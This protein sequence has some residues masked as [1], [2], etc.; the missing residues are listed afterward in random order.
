MDTIARGALADL[1]NIQSV[2]PAARV[3]RNIS[4]ELHDD[5]TRTFA[6]ESTSLKST[7]APS[8]EPENMLTKALGA[9]GTAGDVR[10]RQLSQAAERGDVGQYPRQEYQQA[11][12]NE[13]ERFLRGAVQDVM[14]SSG[15]VNP[16]KLANWTRKNEAILERFPQLRDDLSSAAAAQSSATR[17]AGITQ[18]ASTNANKTKIAAIAAAETPSGEIGKVLNSNNSNRAREYAALANMAGKS[19]PDALEGLGSASIESAFKSGVTSSGGFDFEKFS[20]SLLYKGPDGKSPSLL[21][22]MQTHNVL[23]GAKAGRLNAILER[24]SKLKSAID[25]PSLAENIIGE[26]DA[27]TDFLTR[28]AGSNIGTKINKAL[29]GGGSGASL[30]AASAGS[31]ILRDYFNKIPSAKISTILTEAAENPHFMAM[32]LEKSGTPGQAK[33]ITRQMNAFLFGS[34]VNFMRDQ[35]EEDRKREKEKIPHITIR[36]RPLAKTLDA[37]R[38]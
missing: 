12:N 37:V 29:G 24:A 25:N 19:G 13:Q 20:N 38:Q 5:F 23:D 1:N 36:G 9:G 7:G 17:I 15:R 6:G 31:K 3:A 35:T 8:V 33:E 10:M 32:L 21:D 4:R 22:L 28:V 27:L 26:P 18:K 16:E 11:M 14:D 34:G 2:A 30:I